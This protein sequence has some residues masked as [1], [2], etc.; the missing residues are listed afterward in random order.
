MFIC[1]KEVR[2]VLKLSL[3]N[4]YLCLK[5]RNTKLILKEK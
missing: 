1:K 4:N 3:N 2:E 5:K